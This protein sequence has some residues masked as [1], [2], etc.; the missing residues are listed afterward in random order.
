[1]G[2]DAALS[3]AIVSP[4]TDAPRTMGAP[5]LNFADA[6]ATRGA[7]SRIAEAAWPQ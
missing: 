4:R 6:P 3:A 1:L 2:A 7:A 5:E